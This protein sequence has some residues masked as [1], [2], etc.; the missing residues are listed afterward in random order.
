MKK[1]LA[2]S[3]PASSGRGMTP[4]FPGSVPE[5]PALPASVAEAF[6]RLNVG[7]RARMLR[8]LLTSV[9][10]LALTVVAGG[11]FAK[12]IKHARWP[13]VP[14]SFED[15]ARATSGQVYELARYVQQSNPQLFGQLL[16]LLS[17]DAA[18]IAAIGASITV[19]TINRLAPNRRRGPETGSEL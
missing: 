4:S 12:Y 19:F 5:S 1:I 6:G 10:P 14:V 17:H 9:G 2:P 11:A 3:G 7:L 16:D 13:E 15:A 18:T 8:R